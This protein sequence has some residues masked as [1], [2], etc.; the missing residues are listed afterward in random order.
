M[1]YSKKE[2]VAALK[3]SGIQAGDT[4]FSHSNIGFFGMPEGAGDPGSACKIILDAILG[5]LGKEGSFVVPS[6]TYSFGADKAEKIF[7]VRN[8]PS[9]MGIF[10]EYVRKLPEAKRSLDPMFSISALGAKARELTENIGDECFGPESFWARLHKLGGKICNFNFDSGSTLI[11]YVEKCLN[12]PYRKD[13]ELSGKVI[14]GGKSYPKTI[15]YF[16]RD[17]AS[18]T[19]Y[20]RFERFDELAKKKYAKTS[21]LGR[22]EIVTITA[23]DTYKLIEETLPIESNFLTEAYYAR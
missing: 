22:G 5:V 10:A 12:V 15:I 8:T 13:Y 19:A 17:L 3:A 2:L 20:P 4:V 18:K 11:H 1:S 23:N 21:Q 9:A 14:A 16:A 7:D 6:F